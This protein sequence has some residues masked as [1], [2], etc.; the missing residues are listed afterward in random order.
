MCVLYL[1]EISVRLLCL[2]MQKRKKQA[3]HLFMYDLFLGREGPF[4]VSLLHGDREL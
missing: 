1:Q 3:S 2:T 4:N